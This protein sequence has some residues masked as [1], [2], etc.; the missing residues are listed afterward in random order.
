[1]NY[2]HILFSVYSKSNHHIMLNT[3]LSVHFIIF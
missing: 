3:V 2:S 1:M